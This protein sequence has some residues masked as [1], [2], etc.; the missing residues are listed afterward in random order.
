MN[1]QKGAFGELVA[2]KYLEKLGHKIIETNWTCRWGEIDIIS[3]CS[4]NL[5]FTEVKYRT[6]L[7]FGHPSDALTYKKKS[8]LQ[9][10]INIYLMENTH[11]T[12]WEFWVICLVGD[13][14]NLRLNLYKD[15]F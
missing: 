14:N 13:R 5:I 15:C 1:K 10:S 12:S 3:I 6:T 2:S 8:S 11:S 7:A 9:R 4:G